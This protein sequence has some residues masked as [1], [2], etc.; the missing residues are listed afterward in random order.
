MIEWIRNSRLS[1]KNSL[2]Q[3]PKRV[4]DAGVLA[5]GSSQLT[6]LAGQIIDYQT[7]LTG[8]RAC[9]GRWGVL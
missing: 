5:S 4:R 2:S 9:A 1:L 3:V 8:A 6:I 7:A